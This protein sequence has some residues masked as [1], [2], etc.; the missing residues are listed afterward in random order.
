MKDYKEILEGVVNIINTTEKCDTGFVNI[1]SYIGENCPELKESED[2]QIRKKL[3]EAVKRDMVVGGTKDKQLAI[4][5]LEKQ[6]KKSVDKLKV[7]N[8]LYEH[9]RNTYTC[10][11]NA[12]RPNTFTDMTNYLLTAAR[13]A[14]SA[15]DM[16][17][18]QGE[19]KLLDYD[20]FGFKPAIEV[21]TEEKVDNANKVEPKFKV[22][23]WVVTDKCDTVQIGAVNN[24]YYTLYN[25]M[26]FNVSYV[27]KCWHLWT[28]ADAKPGDVLACE[29][30]WICI[31]RCL[32]DNLFS[33]HCFMDDEGWFCEYGGQGHT[34]DN[35]IC[36]EIHPATKEQR[37]I[38]FAKMKEA[39][40]EWDS[41]KKQPRKIE[42]KP[43]VEW[44]EEDKKM[45][46]SIYH[47][48]NYESI[49]EGLRCS[50][51]E[52]GDDPETI[53]I[54]Q[55][56]WLKSI[57]PKQKQEWSEK[58]E[59]MLYNL[60]T[61]IRGGAHFAYEEEIEWLKSLSLRYHWR[62]SEEMLEALDIA[63]RA[64]IHLGTWEEE[65]LRELQ[66]QLKEL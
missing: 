28:I 29:N 57:R 43:A 15:L 60:I 4:A 64:G 7:S 55:R 17:E 24:G 10:I 6:G 20:D 11:Y 33:S 51:I 21:T 8:E 14:Q 40:Y 44:S 53:L 61:L 23:D 1:C 52:Y 5:W 62:P 54:K 16:I 42:Q 2:E 18:N 12:V 45:I 50:G 35:S 47:S 32:N 27:D 58:D 26:I 36:G 56:S 3:I 48:L 63:I 66:K 31:F 19:T 25:G 34:L 59:K 65:A 39:G 46:D 30:G 38:L 37:D 22:G 49:A 9:I 41:E 13:S